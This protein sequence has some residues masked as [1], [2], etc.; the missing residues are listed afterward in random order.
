MLHEPTG[1][2]LG[3]RYQI[4]NTQDCKIFD[5]YFEDGVYFQ[6]VE[7]PVR[8]GRLDGTAFIYNLI[9]EKAVPTFSNGFVGEIRNLVLT[10]SDGTVFGI[11]HVGNG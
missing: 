8:A 1:M 7:H 4:E 2:K 5:G 11:R 3:W 9:D 10:L 6:S